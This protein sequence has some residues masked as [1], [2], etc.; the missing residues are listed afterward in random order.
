MAMAMALAPRKLTVDEVISMAQTGLIGETERLELV[1]G[2]LYEMSPESYD[3][4]D[5]T[6]WVVRELLR[7]YGDEYHVRSN[8]T[9]P[10]GRHTFLQPDAYVVR[11]DRPTW[12]T[13]ADIPL[14]VEV[15]VTSSAYDRGLKASLYAQW[16][17]CDY[18]VI[19]LRQRELVRFTE[20]HDGRYTSTSVVDEGSVV[21]PGTTSE[22]TLA[23]IL[24][25][26]HDT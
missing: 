18:W 21:I 1:D 11:A 2:T 8:S 7:A 20:P 24:R 4:V 3:H 17:I 5:V 26:P 12:P 19:D 10:T 13:P 23:A 6:G 16:G 9:L 25:P 14:V 15:A 22:L